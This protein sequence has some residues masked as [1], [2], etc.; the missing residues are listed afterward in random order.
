MHLPGCPLILHLAAFLMHPVLYKPPYDPVA[1]PSPQDVE[2]AYLKQ[3]HQRLMYNA[4]HSDTAGKEYDLLITCGHKM[5]QDASILDCISHQ[6]L[7]CHK[8]CV[9]PGKLVLHLKQHDYKQYN[10]MWCLRRLQ[11]QHNPCTFCGSDPH[12]ESFVCPALQCF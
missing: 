6:R 10:T 4:G 8:L 11:Q 1:W 9:L 7:L 12:P 2:T 3:E 5:L